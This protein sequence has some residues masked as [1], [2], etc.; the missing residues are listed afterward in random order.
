MTVTTSTH[1]ATDLGR[2]VPPGLRVAFLIAASEVSGSARQLVGT[3]V[4]LG[5]LGVPT[6]VII[7]QRRGQAISALRDHLLGLGVDVH[8]A[9]ERGAFDPRLIGSVR[10]CI[11]DWEPTVLETHG[12]KP[13]AVGYALRRAGAPFGWVGLMHGL[14]SENLKVKIYH[15]L[16]IRAL[17]SADRIV[18]MS[19]QQAALF[20]E[21][22]ERVRVI[23]N[24]VLPVPEGRGPKLELGGL[25]RPLIGVVG[26]LSPEKGVDVFLDAARILHT[27]GV[28]FGVA[29][30]GGGPE[31]ESLEAHSASAGLSE[32]VAFL[33][34]VSR[35]QEF[36]E[37]I[38]LLVIPSRSE[39]LPNV[40]LEALDAGVPVISTRVGSVPAVLGDSGAGMIVDVGAPEALADAI[41][42]FDWNRDRTEDRVHILRRFS[43]REKVGNY[44]DVYEQVM[45]LN[46]QRREST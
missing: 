16:G 29:L 44:L 8:L 32:R 14:T 34:P 9:E 45:K 18:V 22:R 37:A 1:T 36:Y 43:N 11:E 31:R 27:R 3:V 15:Q 46:Q 41:E 33:G 39:G 4:G 17:G 21:D 7:T 10:S 2:P 38:D 35:M 6:R 28:A 23:F 13:H 12:Y 30:A 25:P 24:S 26:R 20:P 40:L 19:E 5:E 42:G